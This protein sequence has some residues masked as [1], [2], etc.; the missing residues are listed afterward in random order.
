[1]HTESSNLSCRSN[2]GKIIALSIEI[3]IG[4]CG[5]GERGCNRCVVDQLSPLVP[6]KACK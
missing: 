1:M 5:E 3:L 4:G 2:G 6:S